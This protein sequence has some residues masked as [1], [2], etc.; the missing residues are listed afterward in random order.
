MAYKE[1][2]QQKG[3]LNDLFNDKI[4][5]FYMY[6]IAPRAFNLYREIQLI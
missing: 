2:T 1:G 3:I 5:M 6:M 4:E